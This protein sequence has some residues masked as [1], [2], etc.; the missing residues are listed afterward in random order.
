MSMK[1]NI[2]V[3]R[4]VGL[5]DFG[6]IGASCGL[7][8]ELDAGLLDRDDGTLGRRIRAAYAAAELAVHDELD[9][10]RQ[11][12]GPGAGRVRFVPAAPQLEAAGSRPEKPPIKQ[13]EERP[14]TPNQLKAIRMIVGRFRID[15]AA[16]LRG[17]FGV[18][19]PEE[20]T[21]GQASKLIDILK[22]RNGV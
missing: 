6:S 21:L 7:E 15:L 22:E 2:G 8:L 13:S 4:K 16:I 11:P 19:R 20:L 14:A 3:S 12:V 5:P 18:P 9:R 10:L 17:E 1:L